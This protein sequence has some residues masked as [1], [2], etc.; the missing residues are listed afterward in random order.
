MDKTPAHEQIESLRVDVE[1]P[2][3]IDR[4]SANTSEFDANKHRLV[5]KLGLGCW[6]CGGKDHLEVHHYIIEWSEWNNADPSKVLRIMHQWDA[7]GFAADGM[8]GGN[9]LPQSPDDLRN[10]MVLCMPCHR[11]AGLG[12]HQVPAPFWFADLV[13]HEGAVVLKP[14]SKKEKYDG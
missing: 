8:K 5:H 13:K 9:P 6:K 12:I 7:Y 4:G 11:G 2:E 10:L 1:Y 3:H 14:I